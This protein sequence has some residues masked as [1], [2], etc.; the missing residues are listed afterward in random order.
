M[1]K[2]PRASMAFNVYIYWKGRRM[3]RGRFQVGSKHRGNGYTGSFAAFTTEWHN[4][5]S[6]KVSSFLHEEPIFVLR[7]IIL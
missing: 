7:S 3:W 2:N 4:N 5:S 1:A 6:N